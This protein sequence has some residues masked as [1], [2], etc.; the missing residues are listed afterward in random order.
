VNGNINND[1]VSRLTPQIL[2]LQSKDRSP[3]TVYIDSPG[4]LVS[5][6][7]AIL[8]LLK[9]SDQDSSDPC[10]IIT[11]VTMRAGSAAA[12]LLSSGDYSIA[13]PSSTVLYHGLRTYEQ[14]ALTFE[15][16]SVLTNIL[17]LSNDR[18]AMEL[19]R[20]IEDRFS[21][22]YMSVRDEFADFRTRKAAPA[23]TDLDC[24]IEVIGSKLSKNAK[25]V[26]DKA[27]DRHGRYQA[28]LASL[29]RALSKK[30]QIG[31]DR[32][33]E[34]EA[35]SIR[36]IVDFEMKANKDD[37]SW[38]F[39]RGGMDRLAD[40]F[41]LLNEY[42]TTYG[43][44]RL[45]NWCKLFGKW[46]LPK[47]DADEIDAITDEKLRTEK[48]VEK[49]RPILQ[50]IWGFF[51][52]LCH[53]LQEGENELTAKDAYWLGLVDEVVGEELWTLRSFVEYEPEPPSQTE[54][55]E[56]EKIT[57]EEKPAAAGA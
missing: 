33:A 56:E 21:F 17:R 34:I 53:A 54:Q 10:H 1:L 5:S 47:L 38:T 43:D 28:L 2:K 6:M 19:A 40:D 31:S 52:A 4:G 51:I 24:F 30:K 16:T 11:A 3:I 57:S 45:T 25:K 27:T 37:P 23:M 39:R 12:D 49:V 14:N 50:P 22:R 29:E 55:N 35:V 46:V 7:E 18:Y 20:K 44:E 9:L 48:L 42:M 36:A 13:F 41:F 32:L 26:W 8:R 15:S